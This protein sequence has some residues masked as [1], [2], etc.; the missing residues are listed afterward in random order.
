MQQN[1]LYIHG[2]NSSPLSMKAKQTRHYLAQ[3]FPQVNFVCPQLANSPNDAIAQCRQIIQRNEMN[4]QWYL[5]GSSLG[6]YF[7]NDLSNQ[8]NVPAVLINPAVKPFEL[9]TDYIGEQINPYTHEVYQVSEHHIDELKAM[10]QKP[11]SIDGC[12]K[13]NYLVMV[14]TDDEVLNYQHAV[15]KYQ[16][17]RLIV[18]QGGDHSFVGFEQHLP[19]IA[20]FFQLENPSQ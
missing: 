7:S 10:E 15:K 5:I 6:G 16:H 1:V 11:P 20:N 2:F 13:N 8:F 9:L 18:E 17:C 12:Q 4:N 3:N 19:T 14:Q